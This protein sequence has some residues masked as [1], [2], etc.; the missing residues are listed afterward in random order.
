[1]TIQ[2]TAP[3]KRLALPDPL[4]PLT[5]EQAP[6]NQNLDPLRVDQDNAWT[7]LIPRDGLESTDQFYIDVV[8]ETGTPPEASYTLGPLSLGGM[9]PRTVNLRKSIVA[10]LLDKKVTLTYTIVRDRGQP[11][12][13]EKTSGPLELKVSALDVNEPVARIL[14]AQDNGHGSEL[15]LTTGIGNLTARLDRWP[16]LAKDQ[17]VGVTLKGK[18]AEG[19][20]HNL[21]L[22][23]LPESSV[24]QRWEDLGYHELPIDRDYL[25]GLGNNTT[26]TIEHQVA[27]DR[28]HDADA[29]VVFAH[30]PYTVKSLA[31][32]KPFIT[33]VKDSKGN[34][35]A[36]EGATFD[37]QLK[38]TGTAAKGGKVDIYDGKTRLDSATVS[39]TGWTYEAT[40]LTAKAY[41]FKAK[42][43]YGDEPESEPWAV[44]VTAV[45][46]QP[47]IRS[48]T[49]VDGNEIRG[50]GYTASTTVELSGTASPRQEVKLFDGN[51]PAGTATADDD[52]VWNVTL[53][54]LAERLHVIKVEGS[55]VTHERRFSVVDPRVTIITVARDSSG[56]VI[57]WNGTTR[58]R[59]VVLAG[60]GT[61]NEEIEIKS[62]TVLQG[63]T[64][65]NTDGR[66][67]L[68][69]NVLTDDHPIFIAYGAYSGGL[70]LQTYQF[71]IF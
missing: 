35:V 13:E 32:A 44:T 21:T 2:V 43:L 5:V 37:T 38:L 18:D 20:D 41:N 70:V 26:L 68:R 63:K 23:A 34:D 29:V 59:S 28:G 58:D 16:L 22:L 4:P 61:A 19:K 10:L 50:T 12:E 27:F 67:E 47:W 30:R 42:G 6:D 55:N 66:W 36:P 24:S 65:V 9:R 31:M 51:D 3:A 11:G 40:G 49:D 17:L 14:E 8:G 39:G 1:M 25:A 48:V 7:A 56:N 64:R 46:G 57:P 62:R 45:A 52:G 15:D 53:E 54:G 69:L 71:R 33:G 60:T